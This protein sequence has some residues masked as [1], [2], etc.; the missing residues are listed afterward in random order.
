MWSTINRAFCIYQ[1][2]KNPH[3]LVLE[4]EAYYSVIPKCLIRP[5][6]ST[7]EIGINSS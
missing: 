7:H 5:Q 6:D 1:F 3:N 2:Q 4:L